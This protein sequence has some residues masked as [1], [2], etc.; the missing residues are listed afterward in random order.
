MQF[1]RI[2]AL[3]KKVKAFFVK[4]EKEI[5]RQPPRQLPN[6]APLHRHLCNFFNTGYYLASY[7]Y[8]AKAQ[9]GNISSFSEEE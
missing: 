1:L 3:R 4:S 5:K 2:A 8:V 7:Y 6:N 9:R